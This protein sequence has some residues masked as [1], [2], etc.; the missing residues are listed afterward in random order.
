[1]KIARLV[2][3]TSFLLLAV[4]EFT[5]ANE[6][7]CINRLTSGYSS[8]SMSHTL[9]LNDYEI[10]DYR[11]DHLAFS[12]RMVR[13]LL[14][15]VGCSKNAINFGRSANG[16][17]HS[18]CDQVLRSVPSSRVCYVETNLGYF[19]VTRNMLTNIH[20]TFNRWD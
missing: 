1:M 7:R 8:D 11:N 19:F 12:I 6:A 4:S 3:I 20:I 10:R 5:S 17:S 9:D 2:L 18:R 13:E 15:D 14:N 16:R